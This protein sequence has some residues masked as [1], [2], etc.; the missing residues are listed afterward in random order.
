MDA[1]RSLSQPTMGLTLALERDG[2]GLRAGVPLRTGGLELVLRELADRVLLFAM[3][4]R[5]TEGL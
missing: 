5:F 4:L 1:M 2:A 3:I